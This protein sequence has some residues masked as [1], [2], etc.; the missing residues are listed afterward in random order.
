MH[1]ICQTAWTV[2]RFGIVR[3]M[4]LK[5]YKLCVFGFP[6]AAILAQRFKLTLWVESLSTHKNKHT[7]CWE[8]C[9]NLMMF[10]LLGVL[11]CCKLSERPQVMSESW[12]KTEIGE[13]SGAGE[14]KEEDY[15][16][17]IQLTIGIWEDRRR[18]EGDVITIWGEGIK[19]EI[20]ERCVISHT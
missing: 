3:K 15:R 8:S 1:K 10:W 9:G 14:V 18:Q 4:M 5:I 19:K 16:R 13:Q 12:R 2:I 17:K 6:V 20:R 7:H 11:G